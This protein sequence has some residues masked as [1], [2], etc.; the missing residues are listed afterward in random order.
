MKKLF[1]LLLVGAVHWANAQGYTE[2]NKLLHRLEQ[3]QKINRE[4]ELHYDLQ[5]K[6]FLL[7]KDFP[8]KTERKVL[9][10]REDN[11]I[12]VIDL[13]DNKSTNKT[14]SKIYTG[15]VVRKDFV[16]SV[17]ADKLE[18]Q[19]IGMPL[20]YLYHLTFKGGIWYLIDANTGDRWID[21]NDLNKKPIEEKLSKKEQRKLEKLQ[22]RQN[23]NRE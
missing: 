6:K 2:L 4:T 23:K 8:D 1:V 22:K 11:M 15:D 13:E 20:T 9:E 3:E 21:T 16:V 10:I 18:G 19:K 7:V 17:R 5:G 12:Q 14:T